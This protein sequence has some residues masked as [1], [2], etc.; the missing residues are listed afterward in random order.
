MHTL[1]AARERAAAEKAAA[2][3]KQ[4]AE[5]KAAAE[6]TAKAEREAAEKAAAEAKA[7]AERE[8]AASAA[9]AAALRSGSARNMHCRVVILGRGGAGK[10]STLRVMMGEPLRAD[11]S[12]T[13]GADTQAVEL[14][15]QL[16]Q[17]GSGD[18]APLEAYSPADDE[19]TQAVVAE[20]GA[21]LL[22]APQEKP[23]S[24]LEALQ[25]AVEPPLSSR[26]SATASE[27][28]PPS[29]DLAA[30]RT[31]APVVEERKTPAPAPA[32]P[33]TSAEDTP[34]PEPRPP[35]IKEQIL[36]EWV[37]KLQHSGRGDRRKVIHFSDTGGQPIF[38]DLH[39][40]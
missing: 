23:V 27:A 21:L 40:V 38:E 29:R 16:V 11:E 28:L 5:A 10:T 7:K 37:I 35:A 33:P 22:E 12:S 31:P 3:H 24:R 20:A 17:L 1:Q 26:G 9:L 13:P 18:G 15:R 32:S 14:N 19:R 30:P 36:P 39:A 34:A 6:A 2:E 25:R 8:A 4:A